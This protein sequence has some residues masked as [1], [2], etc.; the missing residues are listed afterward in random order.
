M[1]NTTRYIFSWGNNE[2]RA[3]MKGRVCVVICRGKMNS[4]LVEF[5]DN[6]QREVISR[7]AIR[8]VK[9]SHSN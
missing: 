6:K 4:C 5:E 9:D 3:T 8:K 1:A 7:N 2:R